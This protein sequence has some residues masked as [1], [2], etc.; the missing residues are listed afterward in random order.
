MKS[1]FPLS[2][3]LF[4]ITGALNAQ[5]TGT[6]SGRVMD[7]QKKPISGTTI[8]I[9]GTSPLRGAV[10]RRDGS[11]I[12]AAIRAG[13]YTV[14]AR[15]TGYADRLEDSVSINVGQETR[16]NFTLAP[17]PVRDTI[18]VD[19]SHRPVTIGV[20]GKHSSV[21]VQGKTFV[22][23]K[24]FYSHTIADMKAVM[25]GI[26]SGHIT[27]KPP[28][29]P[30]VSYATYAEHYQPAPEQDS[31]NIS[32][33]GTTIIEGAG[34]RSG[35]MNVGDPF[36]GGFGA[37]CGFIPAPEK[38]T[39][40]RIGGFEPEYGNV[41]DIRPEEIGTNAITPSEYCRVIG[42]NPYSVTDS[43][44]T[45]FMQSLDDPFSEDAPFHRRGSFPRRGVIAP[46]PDY[47]APPPYYNAHPVGLF[48]KF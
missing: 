24:A 22:Q 2:L 43:R 9:L 31:R 23:G 6:L 26:R 19:V 38:P 42:K 20:P 3:F 14:K 34:R 37:T 10:T 40:Q 28:R 18:T 48:K 33:R 30:K 36:S 29:I 11:Y 16:R 15:G 41:V 47:H 27:P 12:V 46:A 13:T 4:L 35:G 5:T 1:F 44:F 7:Q 21:I 45:S 32:I 39:P 8:I 17:A 25:E